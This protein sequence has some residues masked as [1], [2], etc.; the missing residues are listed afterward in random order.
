MTDAAGHPDTVVVK[1]HV[2][3]HRVPA[4]VAASTD[5]AGERVFC[6]ERR[7]GG[8]DRY[9][10]GVDD[11]DQ[12]DLQGRNLGGLRGLSRNGS[13]MIATGAHPGFSQGGGG[14]GENFSHV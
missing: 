10:D 7:R 5:R 2:T 1:S 6:W 12:R 9:E 3:D 11:D 8:G 4:T 13:Y 14:G